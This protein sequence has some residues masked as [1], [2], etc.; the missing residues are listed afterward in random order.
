LLG[1]SARANVAAVAPL[2]LDEFGIIM[3][4]GIGLTLSPH[5][6]AAGRHPSDLGPVGMFAIA[7]EVVGVSTHCALV[8]VA[9]LKSV[10]GFSPEYDTRAMDIDLACKLHRVGRHAI[11]TPL[12]SVRSLDDPTLTDRET[13]ALATRWVVCSGTT[14]TRALTRACAYLFLPKPHRG[15][16]ELYSIDQPHRL[17][18]PSW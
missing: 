16:S 12:V 8:D 13:E 4:A 15:E 11:I 18:R 2:L 6:I 9:V 1:Y 17:G 7:R 3:S 10:G 5:H 14:P